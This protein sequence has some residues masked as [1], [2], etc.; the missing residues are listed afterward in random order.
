MIWRDLGWVRPVGSDV[1][2]RLHIRPIYG[3]GL[4]GVEQPRR[5]GWLWEVRLGGDFL[6][7]LS[8]RMFGR[9]EGGE[10]PCCRC[11]NP[12]DLSRTEKLNSLS[13]SKLGEMHK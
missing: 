11:T 4:R 3:M 6:T 10:E 9:G 1:S 5:L 2:G 7:G 12:R 8:A 13:I